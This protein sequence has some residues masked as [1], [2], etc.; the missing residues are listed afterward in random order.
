[1]AIQPSSVLGL[2]LL[3]ISSERL[4]HMSDEFRQTFPRNLETD[5]SNPGFYNSDWSDSKD[6]L[7]AEDWEEPLEPEGMD[8][9]SDEPFEM[10]DEITKPMVQVITRTEQC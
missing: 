5:R 8:D 9:D 6:D 2:H 1:M 4:S 10:D 7:D 3:T